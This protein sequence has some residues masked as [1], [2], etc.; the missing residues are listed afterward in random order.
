MLRCVRD[1]LSSAGYMSIVTGD[2]EGAL[3]LVEE[4]MPDLVLLD[5]V[6]PGTDGIKL[7]KDILGTGDFPVIF[8]SH[9]RPGRA[10]RRAL[11]MG[12]VDYVVKPFSPNELAARIGAALCKR[13]VSEL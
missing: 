9:L 8:P 6:S 13:A 10:H 4:E 2:P 11:Y 5:L 7:M 1:A 12:A 3:R